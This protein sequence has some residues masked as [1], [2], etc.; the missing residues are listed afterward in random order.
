M[1]NTTALRNCPAS[2]LKFNCSVKTFY[3]VTTPV[4]VVLEVSVLQITLP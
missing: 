2:F 3:L 4:L 1:T